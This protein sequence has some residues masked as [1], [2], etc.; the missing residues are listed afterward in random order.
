MKSTDMRMLVSARYRGDIDLLT[1]IRQDKVLAEEQRRADV[2]RSKSR[3]RMRLLG[4]AMRVSDGLLPTVSESLKLIAS[5]VDI[6][7]PLE[8]FVFSEGEVNAFVCEASS[9]FLVGLSS[10]AVN[11]LS[12]QELEFVI[13]HELGH[14]LFGHTEVAAGYLVEND[15]VSNDHTKLLRAWQRSSEISADRVGLLCC[16]E[17]EVAATALL[18]TLAG[19]PLSGHKLRL[20]DVSIQW[21]ALLEEVMDEGA[22]DLWEHS[23]PFP[24]LRIQALRAFWGDYQAG[25]NTN[26]D[27][28]VRRLLGVMDAP[29]SGRVGAGEEGLL[30]RFLLWGGLFVG[31]SDGP[32]DP[33][34]KSRLEALTVSG[35]DI[36]ALV[37]SNIDLAAHALENFRAARANRRSKLRAPELTSLMRQLVAFAA[38]DNVFTEHERV[39]LRILAGELGLPER[40][41]D[42]LIDQFQE[43]KSS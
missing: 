5:R 40:S 18:K 9:R 41:V 39:R 37:R 22:L 25:R 38:L 27:A 7:K 23:H 21:E 34:V 14:A 17:L 6:G 26:G 12:V 33:A 11:T 1:T 16:G 28:E 20:D 30:A 4:N 3:M 42:L 2:L 32:L 13:G 31:T 15:R 35:V 8:A 43:G 24:P 10:G 19:L 36:D 29:G